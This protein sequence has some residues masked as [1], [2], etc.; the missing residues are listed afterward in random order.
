MTAD[1]TTWIVAPH[2]PYMSA[3][4]PVVRS[5]YPTA[6]TITCNEGLDVFRPDFFLVF[7]MGACG[8]YR[9]RGMEAQAEGTKLITLNWQPHVRKFRGMK[10]CD[11]FLTLASRGNELS[12]KFVRG[13]YADC[14]FSRLFALQF[15]INSGATH[16]LFLGMEGY[17]VDKRRSNSKRDAVTAFVRSVLETCPDVQFDFC[18]APEYELPAT[19]NYGIYDTPEQFTEAYELCEMGR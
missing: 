17:P 7:D 3:F 15:A 13:S 11:I 8:T 18:G 12:A 4:W 14:G 1:S 2:S 19:D 5:V 9:Q 10:H 6:Q 16:I